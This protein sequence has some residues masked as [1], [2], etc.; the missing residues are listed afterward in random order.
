MMLKTMIN[1][2]LFF[3]K[4]IFITRPAQLA[5]LSRSEIDPELFSYSAYDKF[6]VTFMTNVPYLT[7]RDKKRKFLM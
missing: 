3:S 6:L 4:T 7:F 1:A 2:F 5:E